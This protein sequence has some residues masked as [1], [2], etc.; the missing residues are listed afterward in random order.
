MKT[1]VADNDNSARAQFIRSCDSL[2]HNLDE[3][4]ITREQ[5][6]QWA[7]E[8]ARNYNSKNG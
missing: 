3:G 1:I 5:Y 7:Q 2:K 4:K 8:E 6:D